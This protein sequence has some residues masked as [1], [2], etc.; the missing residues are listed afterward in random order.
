VGRE[1]LIFQNLG[2]LEMAM[3]T[4]LAAREKNPS[5]SN[6]LRFQAVKKFL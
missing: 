4:P 1:R 6:Q 3:S 2:G 5:A